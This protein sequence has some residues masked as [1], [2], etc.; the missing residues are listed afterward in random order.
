MLSVK[1]IWTRLAFYLTAIYIVGV[2]V[3]ATAEIYI[4]EW[5]RGSFT[6]GSSPQ[7]LCNGEREHDYHDGVMMP[8]KLKQDG[9]DQNGFP[10][11]VCRYYCGQNASGPNYCSS[12]EIRAITGSCSG[13]FYGGSCSPSNKPK[14][15]G[16]PS[17]GAG[18]PINIASG[19]KF[20]PETDIQLAP[21]RV[22]LIRYYNSDVPEDLYDI[23]KGW[24]HSFDYRLR[25]TDLA[26]IYLDLP[27]GRT[28]SFHRISGKWLTDDDVHL[29]IEK[30][31]YSDPEE[32]THVISAEVLDKTHDR[33]LIFSDLLPSLTARAQ[34]YAKVSSIE[35]LDG[36]VQNFTYDADT[37]LSTVQD[38]RENQIV[39]G[40]A[41]SSLID[42]ITVNGLAFG[43]EYQDDKLIQVNQPEGS[44]RRYQYVADTH[45]LNAI[46]DENDIEFAKWQYDADGHAWSS[47]HAGQEA[48]TVERDTTTGNM[49]VRNP[50]GKET[51]YRFEIINGVYQVTSVEG[52]ASA[53]CLAANTS[54][55]YDENGFRDL[56][57]DWEGN[58][59]D[60]DHDD[61]GREIRRIEAKGT[62]DERVIETQW[63][64]TFRLPIKITEPDRITEFTYDDNGRLRAKTIKPV[65]VN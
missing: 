53:N 6:T 58:V 49:T 20:Q 31:V 65:A 60:Y 54:Y 18:N 22:S 29:S 51:T 14:N 43:Y 52:H 25:T 48:V 24:R 50:L 4:K 40:Y 37:R 64:A 1:K 45:W 26:V 28:L 16:N 10:K 19:N 17:C 32:R 38:N 46:I 42:S 3:D 23:G 21:Q 7:E 12:G 59:T 15:K 27:D 5:R 39:F 36:Y 47:E 33:T 55:T 34:F 61:Q 57:T 30:L 8:D 63:H 56:V 13:T 62:A 2:S 35:Y 9:Y 11:Y 44:H 41:D